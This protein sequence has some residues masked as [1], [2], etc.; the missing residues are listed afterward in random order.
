[1]LGGE[2]M[3]RWLSDIIYFMQPYIQFPYVIRHVIDIAIVAY[4]LY[5][6]ILL[7][8]K[9][10]AEQVLKGLATLLAITWLSGALQLNTVY[11]ILRNT[12][13][14]GVI[15]LLVVFQPEL[16]RALE[17]IGR[18]KIFEKAIFPQDERDID[19]IIQNITKAVQS[20]S[21][22][23]IGALIVIERQT[24]INDVIETGVAI[25]GQLSQQLLENI[26]VVNTPLHDGAVVLREDR[27][28]AAGCFLPLTQNP[29]VDKQLG[30]R[31]RA[32]LGITE[33]SDAIAIVVSEETGI[34]SMADD[35][36]LTRYLDP[37]ILGDILK[38][39]YGQDTEHW[40]FDLK[41]WR[42]KNE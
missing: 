15:A 28:A 34:I 12:A 20:M 16:R 14:V 2:N 30:T 32:A 22:D 27:I 21:K 5:R 35:G 17:Q 25:D 10:Q 36:K 31:H 40:T 23:K 26:F 11:W 8:Q 41:K 4:V 18:G 29:N 3:L 9:T 42:A 6:L 33:K 19:Y 24:G 13:T 1:M 7:I 37:K 39:I 38:N